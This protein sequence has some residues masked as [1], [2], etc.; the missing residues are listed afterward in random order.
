MQ[1]FGAREHLDPCWL[2]LRAPNDLPILVGC[3]TWKEIQIEDQVVERVR[4]V[5]NV[6]KALDIL[7]LLAKFE[8]SVWQA[9][10]C[11]LQAV[12]L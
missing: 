10:A 6:L 5:M 7:C 1:R 9:C 11:G 12:W 8:H 4:V 2:S 3:I